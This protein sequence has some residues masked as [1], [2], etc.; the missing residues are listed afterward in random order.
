M[1]LAKVWSTGTLAAMG[2]ASV[3]SLGAA[4]ADGIHRAS[5]TRARRARGEDGLHGDGDL[6]ARPGGWGYGG[7]KGVIL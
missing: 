7:G 5:R 6:G 1:R 3:K 4:G 2:M